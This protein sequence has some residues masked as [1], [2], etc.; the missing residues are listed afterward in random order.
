MSYLDLNVSKDDV[1]KAVSSQLISQVD[2]NS[3]EAQVLTLA[4]STIESSLRLKK[5]F[6]NETQKLIKMLHPLYEQLV[7]FFDMLKW[8]EYHRG[9]L[10]IPQMYTM[11]S[12]IVHQSDEEEKNESD[13]I[14]NESEEFGSYLES[15]EYDE[16][17]DEEEEEEQDELE[18]HARAQDFSDRDRKKNRNSIGTEQRVRFANQRNTLSEGSRSGNIRGDR[19]FQNQRRQSEPQMMRSRNSTGDLI[20]GRQASFPHGNDEISLSLVVLEQVI[21][22]LSATRKLTNR[23]VR[24]KLKLFLRKRF[25][26]KIENQI[27]ELEKV[28]FNLRSANTDLKQQ[29]GSARMHKIGVLTGWSG[30]DNIHLDEAD[31][32]VEEGKRRQRTEG[33]H[34]NSALQVFLAAGELGNVPGLYEAGKIVDETSEPWEPPSRYLV[35]AARK[36]HLDAIILLGRRYEQMGL[37]G[38]QQGAKSKSKSVKLHF[39]RSAEWYEKAAEQGS[40]VALCSLGYFAEKG[41]GRKISAEQA[42]NYYRKATKLGSTVAMTNLGVMYFE[43]RM[44]RNDDTKAVKWFEKAIE[45]SKGKRHTALN[46]LGICLELG[47]GTIKDRKRAR[48]LYTQS[49]SAG[50]LNA[51]TNLGFM[52]MQEGSLE[53]AKGWLNRAIDRGSTEAM[54]LMG[55]I[56]MREKN[57]S[58]ALQYFMQVIESSKPCK[59]LPEALRRAANILYVGTKK[60]KADRPQAVSLYQK[61]ASQG[62]AEAQNSLGICYEEGIYVEKDLTKAAELFRASSS[63][64]N[65]NGAFNLGIMILEGRGGLEEDLETTLSLFK[66]AHRSGHPLAKRKILEVETHLKGNAKH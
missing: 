31:Q 34:S 53:A 8:I 50:N 51:M 12:K 21:S 9:G 44:V 32:L 61:A 62:D 38:I 17:D 11:V 42:L 49:A 27:R 56:L 16:D 48:Q 55:V 58:S 28:H 30:V 15:Y 45:L 19:Q 10:N 1:H 23:V 43:G 4:H 40:S 59:H 35:Q 52:D 24:K 13:G 6:K 33:K 46:C 65:G 47:R 54:H 25:K 37:Q 29:V 26:K 41:L 5:R 39:Q 14:S 64:G 57:A 3:A 60:Q 20:I 36:E 22:C 66:K 18:D 2:E 7:T 63:Q